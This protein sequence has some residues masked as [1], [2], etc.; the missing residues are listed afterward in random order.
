MLKQ[1]EYYLVVKP[2]S[3]RTG[4]YIE[5]IGMAERG[6]TYIKIDIADASG[7]IM[8]TFM[9]SVSN[10]GYFYYGFHADMKPGQYSVLATN[11]ALKKKINLPL[12]ITAPGTSGSPAQTPAT[13]MTAA[14]ASPETTTVPAI[15]RAGLTPG[16]LILGLI[17]SGAVAIIGY[18]RKIP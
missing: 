3:A 5:L 10:N 2:S 8:H 7:T 4:D 12:T 16:V 17:I 11:P 15:T 9:A 18:R 14:S 6:V 13:E 1:P